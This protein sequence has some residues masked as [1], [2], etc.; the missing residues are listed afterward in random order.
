[1]DRQPSNVLFDSRGHVKLCDFGVVGRLEYTIGK[2]QTFVGTI[3]YMSV[4]TE[5][6]R[7]HTPAKSVSQSGID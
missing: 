6:A 1:M 5:Q 7:A 2:A 3:T 4:C